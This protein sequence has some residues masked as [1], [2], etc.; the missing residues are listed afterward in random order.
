M[1]FIFA[2]R[3]RRKYLL[4]EAI[5]EEE[6]RPDGFEWL[7]LFPMS[8]MEWVSHWIML[9]SLLFLMYVGKHL[10]TE[11][12]K[13]GILVLFVTVPIMYTVGKT[14]ILWSCFSHK[15]SL[16]LIG[17]LSIVGL[18]AALVFRSQKSLFAAIMAGLIVIPAMMISFG[19]FV[20]IMVGK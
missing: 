3:K 10:S 15:V 11:T 19:I 18:V 16:S 12:R 9:I 13:N 14:P 17:I 20:I 7:H 6:R 5:V 1:F 8:T 2:R 4:E